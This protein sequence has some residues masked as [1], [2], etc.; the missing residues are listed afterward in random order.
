MNVASILQAHGLVPTV[1]SPRHEVGTPQTLVASHVPS[2]P[3]VPTEK[4][5]GAAASVDIRPGLQALAD[6]LGLDDA[7]VRQIPAADLPMWATV[8]A[9]ALQSCLLAL[10]DA[11]TRRAGKVPSVDTAVIRCA[12]CGPVY[13]HPAV[14]AVLPVVAGWPR[15]IGCPWCVVRKAGG[16]LPPPPVSAPFPLNQRS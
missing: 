2:V 13:V 9:E 14:A 11:T 3:K 7:I 16:D 8:P 12:H 10:N 1:P 15:A 6:R 5:K 4:G